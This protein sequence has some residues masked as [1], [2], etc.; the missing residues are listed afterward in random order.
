MLA[1]ATV[2]GFILGGISVAGIHVSTR[3]IIGCGIIL[4]ILTLLVAYLR[5]RMK[6]LP[7]LF[8]DE[9][10]LDGPY[11][12]DFCSSNNLRE[13][14]ELTK[15]FYGHEYVDCS[16]AEDWRRKNPKSF[17]QITNSQDILCACFGI[18]ALSDSFMEQFIAGR[19]AD[20]QLLSDSICSFDDSIKCTRLYVSGVVVRDSSTYIGSKRARV[21]VWSM[22]RYLQKIYGLKRK[23]E[24]YAI[25]VTKESE[26][27]M[28][29]LDFQ[30]VQEGRHRV[31]KCNLYQYDLSKESWSR[32]V[33][34]IGD[35][36]PMT[37]INF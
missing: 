8:V 14:C 10:G 9:M 36:S 5:G 24:L 33:A 16:I 29:H 32:L 21:M 31:D 11:V 18:L 17:V 20:T 28:K 6:L 2:G 35:F 27:L 22:L 37:T 13:A 4:V 19:R 25:G 30:L 7:A 26:K 1:V 15:P 12:C 3:L 23:R 34:L